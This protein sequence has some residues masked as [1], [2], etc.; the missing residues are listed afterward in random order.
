MSDANP[1]NAVGL[2]AFVRMAMAAVLPA[3]GK[4]VLPMLIAGTQNRVRMTKQVGAAADRLALVSVAD[5]SQVRSRPLRTSL[6]RASAVVRGLSASVI[7]NRSKRSISASVSVLS[8]CI[9]AMRS[10][11]SGNV[12][13]AHRD[14]RVR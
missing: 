13:L 10:T 8:N 11:A 14:N 12:A 6:A 7:R 9:Q 4:T 1:W 5:A 2:G 3:I